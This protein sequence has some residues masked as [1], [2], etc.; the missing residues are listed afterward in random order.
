LRSD[1]TVDF[2]GSKF[3]W[4]DYPPFFG[5]N[6]DNVTEV[7]KRRFEPSNW[8]GIVFNSVWNN[9]NN[10]DDWFRYGSQN[11]LDRNV[12]EVGCQ[13]GLKGDFFR[14]ITETSI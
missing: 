11:G 6:I 10:P 8:S 7:N 14:I 12:F 4:T 9:P 13:N 5:N 3:P 2:S 1:D